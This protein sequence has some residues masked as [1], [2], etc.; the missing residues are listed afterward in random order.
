MTADRPAPEALLELATDLAL[1]AGDLALSMREG[2]EVSATKSSP[3][4]VVTAADAAAE[5]LVVDGIR[6][7]RPGDGVLGEEGADDAGTTGVR[8]VVDPVDG[9]VNFLYG[10]PQW[11]VS[12]GVEVDGVT[13]AGVVR[14]PAKDETWRAVRGAGAECISAAEGRPLRCSDAVELS[15]ALLA[16]G[17]SYDARRRAVQ[18][19]HLVTVLPRVRDVRRMGAGA[20]DLCAVAAGRVDAYYEQAMNP[21]DWSAG[22]LVAREAGARV[23]GLRGRPESSDLLVAAAPGVFDALHDLLVSL[24]ADTDPLAAR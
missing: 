1:R 5:R 8:W 18:A 11:A 9:T 7:A 15:Q 6:A 19:Q 17:F 10:L 22:V 14:D 2:V 20:L 23:G 24:E 21:W 12:I 4:D 16:T 13:V 3:T